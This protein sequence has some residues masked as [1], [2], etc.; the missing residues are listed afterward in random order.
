PEAAAAGG[1][2][3]PAVR[4]G[5]SSGLL[6]VVMHSLYKAAGAHTNPLRQSAANSEQTADREA[7]WVPMKKGPNNR[8]LLF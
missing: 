2:E 5:F 7:K 8:T 1:G 6:S 4:F 3:A